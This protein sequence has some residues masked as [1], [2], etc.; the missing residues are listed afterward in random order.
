M[1]TYSSSVQGKVFKPVIC[2]KKLLNVSKRWLGKTWNEAIINCLKALF[3]K[4]VWH[5]LLQDYH[6]QL[7]NK[8]WEEFR[9][10]VGSSR[11][12]TTKCM[13]RYIYETSE[14]PSESR[15][16]SF[17]ETEIKSMTIT[18]NVDF[19]FHLMKVNWNDVKHDATDTLRNHELNE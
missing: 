2:G 14:H 17:E 4:V 9:W 16:A 6:S 1:I 10:N 5:I 13:Y 19:V 11:N 3:S 15:S 8:I 18:R 7:G 12:V